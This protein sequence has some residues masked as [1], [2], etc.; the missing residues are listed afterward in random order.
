MTLDEIASAINR[1]LSEDSASG[2]IINI[3]MHEYSIQLGFYDFQIQVETEVELVS[4]S[5]ATRVSADYRSRTDES[6]SIVNFVGRDVLR[7]RFDD[8]A[9]LL[10]EMD[11]GEVVRCVARE[12]TESFHVTGVTDLPLT[13]P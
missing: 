3:C 5:G 4:E 2:R 11:G 10:L 13:L 6:S 1:V 9:N 8:E 7:C 12:P